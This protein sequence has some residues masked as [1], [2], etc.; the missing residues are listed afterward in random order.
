VSARDRQVGPTCRRRAHAGLGCADQ[1]RS[2]AKWEVVGPFRNSHVFPFYFLF[3]HFSFLLFLDLSFNFKFVMI[4]HSIFFP[5][6]MIWINHCGTNLSIYK[7][8]FLYCIAFFFL[9]FQILAFLLGFNFPFGYLIFFTLL[10]VVT[11]CTHK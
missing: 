3:F 7:F 5:E 8:Y 4:L 6:Y 2:W 11:K 1:K 9:S 10:Y